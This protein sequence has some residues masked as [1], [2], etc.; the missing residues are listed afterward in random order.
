MCESQTKAL[1]NEQITFF[2]AGSMAEAIIRGMTARSVV[3][4]G[5]ITV[6]NRSN[7]ARLEELQQ[8]CGV[9][10]QT[11]EAAK[12]ELLRRSPVIVLAMKPKDA[13]GALGQLGPLLSDDQLI[14]SLIAGLSIRTIQTL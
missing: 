14:I 9:L 3:Q 8:Q 10:F 2:G 12:T 1:I 5:G 4:R 13:A 7:Q 11:E 6:I